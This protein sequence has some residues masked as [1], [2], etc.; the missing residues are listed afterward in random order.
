MPVKV[1]GRKADTI[2]NSDEGPRADTTME[3]LGKLKPAF[4]KADDPPP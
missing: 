1:A 4:E 3:T 2:V